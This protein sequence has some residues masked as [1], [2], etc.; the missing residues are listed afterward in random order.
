MIYR[1]YGKT[2]KKV[3]LL[4]FGC[5]RFDHIDDHEE[6]VKMIVTAAQGGVNYFDTA[7][8]YFDIKSETVLGKGLAELRRLGLPYYLATKTF[9]STEKDIRIE[10]EAQLKRLGTSYIDFYHIWCINSL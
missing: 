7:P 8:A 5:M 4:G 10:I 3:S 1:E 6:C 9:K 2:G